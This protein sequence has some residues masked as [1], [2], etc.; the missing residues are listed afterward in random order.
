MAFAA[1]YSVL[2]VKLLCMIKGENK[3][4]KVCRFGSR[5]S[6]SGPLLP[7]ERC[8]GSLKVCYSLH[9]RAFPIFEATLNFLLYP[10]LRKLHTGFGFK[11]SNCISSVE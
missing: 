6:E 4:T 8:P 10:H 2:E 3:S 9:V 5:K 1:I 11:L 7:F